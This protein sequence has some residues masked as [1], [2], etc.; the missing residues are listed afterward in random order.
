MNIK[1]IAEFVENKQIEEHLAK[2]N[3]DYAQ[4]YGVEKPR[5]LNEILAQ[6]GEQKSASNG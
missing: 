5:P 1:T 6:F 4:G 3:V 2:I